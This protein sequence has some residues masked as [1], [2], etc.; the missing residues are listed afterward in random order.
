MNNTIHDILDGNASEGSLNG[1]SQDLQ[2]LAE[3]RRLQSAL[4]EHASHGALSSADKAAIGSAL[5]ANI[6]ATGSPAAPVATG[7][8]GSWIG[9]VG[10]LLLGGLLGAGFFFLMDQDET[11]AVAP[12]IITTGIIIEAEATTPALFP[13]VLPEPTAHEEC[14]EKIDELQSQI[15]A[16]AAAKATKKKATRK[17]RSRRPKYEKPVTGD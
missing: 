13:F 2:S 11:E 8:G 4:K 17:K 9:M 3:M 14:H 16:M 7:G 10:M 15:D 5:A 1:S 12:E 6:G